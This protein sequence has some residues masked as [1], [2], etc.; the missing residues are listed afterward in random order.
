MF[1]FKNKNNN[2]EKDLERTIKDLE[3]RLRA[4]TDKLTLKMAVEHINWLQRQKE[5]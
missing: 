4:E 3:R 2:T 1:K 5:K